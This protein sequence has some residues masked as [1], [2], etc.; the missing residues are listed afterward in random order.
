MRNRRHAEKNIPRWRFWPL[1]SG[2][3]SPLRLRSALHRY[4]VWKALIFLQPIRALLI[5]AAYGLV[6]CRHCKDLGKVFTVMDFR[7]FTTWPDV[8]K[9]RTH[10]YAVL[11][12]QSLHLSNEVQGLLRSQVKGLGV[13]VASGQSV[14]TSAYQEFSPNAVSRLQQSSEML[15]ETETLS[16]ATNMRTEPCWKMDALEV[17]AGSIFT[18]TLLARNGHCPCN[19]QAHDFAR[20]CREMPVKRLPM[21]HPSFQPAA[22]FELST[23]SSIFMLAAKRRL[24]VNCA[25]PL[26]VPLGCLIPA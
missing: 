22:M 14:Q 11:V 10:G 8:S 21:S 18:G 15:L 23:T 2:H 16:R 4:C 5:R 3:S 26:A 7:W 17:L 1:Q 20:M 19:S 25:L 24:K 6:S 12:A 13:L 9:A